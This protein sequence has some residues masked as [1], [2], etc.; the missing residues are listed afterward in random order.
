[1]R[2]SSLAGLILA[3]TMAAP[4]MAQN[5]SAETAPPAAAAPAPSGAD[6]A[7]VSRITGPEMAALL[8][9]IGWS[10]EASEL[11]GKPYVS[12]TYTDAETGASFD[13]TVGLYR[14]D[15]AKAC[16]DV[17]FMRSMEASKPV[18]LM[19][20]NK[21]NATQMF[22]VAY[23]NDDGSLGLSMSQTLQG[24]VTRQNLKELADWWKTII[25]GFDAKVT[26]G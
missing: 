15:D 10:A 17:M 7:L 1:M 6:T 19:M 21:Y 12:V 22:G 4:A 11:E 24:G 16:Y 23:L 18:T 26:G 9:E 5:G 3:A 25:T 14:C 20:V 8:K 13:F 2:Y